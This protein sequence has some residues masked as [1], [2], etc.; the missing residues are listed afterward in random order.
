MISSIRQFGLDVN[1]SRKGSI[2]E[3][4]FVGGLWR[5]IDGSTIRSF[6]TYQDAVEN[7]TAWEDLQPQATSD[8]INQQMKK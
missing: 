7:K 3:I 2:M 8:D 6:C 4:R 1:L 5:R